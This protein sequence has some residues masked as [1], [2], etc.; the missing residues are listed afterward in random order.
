MSSYALALTTNLIYAL[1]EK[2][3]KAIVKVF[4]VLY[5]REPLLLNKSFYLFK[6]NSL[7]RFK[8]GKYVGKY[9]SSTI[10]A[11]KR[12]YILSK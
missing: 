8:L 4:R 10:K 6:K 9:I 1:K 2:G 7:I 3:F 12:A 5:L 11:L